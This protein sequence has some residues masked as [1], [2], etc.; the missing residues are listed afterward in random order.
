M[1]LVVL[2]LTRL[3]LDTGLSKDNSDF[4]R[5]SV[6]AKQKKL[7]VVRDKRKVN[8]EVEE[9][10]LS[11]AIAQDNAAIEA[12]MTRRVHIKQCLWHELSIV[13]HSRQAAQATLGWRKFAEEKTRAH[14]GVAGLWQA[15]ATR[16]DD[17]PVD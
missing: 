5:K 9:E 3:R 4:L 14:K 11:S 17:M 1:C 2:T 13:L 16:L 6:D 8:W 7:D 10:K 12:L 15:L